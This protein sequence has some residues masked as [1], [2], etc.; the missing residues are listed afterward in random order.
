MPNCCIIQQ[1][2]ITN[3]LIFFDILRKKKAVNL[4]QLYDFFL[5]LHN[6]DSSIFCLTFF[7]VIISNWFGG[8]PAFG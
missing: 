4:R 5:H 3:G 2:P 6:F 7:G 8:A 1:L